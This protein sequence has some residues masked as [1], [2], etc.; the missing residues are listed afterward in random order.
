MKVQLTVP[1]ASAASVTHRTRALDSETS[2]A[3]L[4]Q[5]RFRFVFAL[6][7]HF[8]AEPRA[9]DDPAV[10]DGTCAAGECYKVGDARHE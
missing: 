5:G 3:Q 4:F 8:P 7:K 9:G 10:P 2:V 6:Q 1:F